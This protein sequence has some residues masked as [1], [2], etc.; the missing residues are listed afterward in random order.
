VSAAVQTPSRD[1]AGI[2]APQL[3]YLLLFAVLGL[4]ALGLVM[5]TSASMHKV[6]D[7]P[8]HYTGR[9]GLAMVLGLALGYLL[10]YLPLRRLE[11]F[12]PWLYA[13]GLAM[14][15]LVLIPGVG[16][17][18]NG[19]VRWIAVGPFN[20]QGSEFMKLFMVIYIAGYIVRREKEVVHSLW[21]ST[22][23]MLL[24]AVACGLLLMEP[25][26][27]TTMV[28]VLTVL[29][30]LF[31][32]GV[33][34]GYFGGL[35]GLVG[36]L[37]V[38]LIL[39]EPYRLA[40]VTSF[41][42]P[43]ADP[44]NSGFQ[45]TQALI[46]FGRGEWFGVGLGAGIQKL[47]YLPEAHTDFL[48]AVIGEELGLAGTLTVIALVGVLIW[49]SFAIGIKAEQLGRR[50]AAYLAYGFGTWIFVQA[51]INIG[52]NTGL[53]PTKGLTLPFMSYGSNSIIAACLIAAILLRIDRENRHPG[54]QEATW[55]QS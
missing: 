9:H 32:G 25:D 46:A 37:T 26:F 55:Q 42:D 5:V 31:L 53:F 35:L 50:F 1:E 44:L 16:K 43:W 27:G 36:A 14:L 51:A 38:P 39:F 49:R 48:L 47:F 20:F 29:G 19:A 22:K 7:S 30:M 34:V 13:V 4:L 6:G 12:G 11:Q 41:L 33:P 28:L 17:E 23:P 18:V 24:V 52:V 3:D 2:A 10:L 40:R 15:L 21:G 45:L 54:D 8:F